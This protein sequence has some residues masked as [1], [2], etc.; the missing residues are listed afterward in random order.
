MSKIKSKNYTLTVL[1]EHEFQWGNETFI[2]S[3]E[4]SNT[5]PDKNKIGVFIGLKENENSVGLYYFSKEKP[6]KEAEEYIMSP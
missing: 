5:S 4:P 2:M 1:D 6:F 3:L